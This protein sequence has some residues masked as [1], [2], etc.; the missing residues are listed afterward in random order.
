MVKKIE[1]AQKILNAQSKI[2]R[3]GQNIFELADGIGIR[4]LLNGLV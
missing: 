2:S 4:S 3:H 1:L